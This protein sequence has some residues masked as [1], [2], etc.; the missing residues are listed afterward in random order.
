MVNE[1]VKV[2]LRG[3][4]ND[5][6]IRRY[7][8]ADGTSVSKGQLLELADDRTAVAATFEAP[9]A[10]VASAEHLPNV[11]DTSI[12]VWTDGIFRATASGA[13]LI[14]DYL[15]SEGPSNM[16]IASSALVDSATTSASI[17]ILSILKTHSH[18][19]ALDA[20]TGG[21]ELSVDLKV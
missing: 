10:G 15:T 4:N 7:T 6:E 19:R 17:M 20:V 3:P 12:P 18:I 5:G 14:G 2:E 9:I 8:I 21:E 16:V 13:I 11:G 1:W